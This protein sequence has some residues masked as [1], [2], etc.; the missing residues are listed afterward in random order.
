ML[1]DKQRKKKGLGM[2]RR[3]PSAITILVANV[4][5]APMKAG[6]LN[7]ASSPN[8]DSQTATV[9]ELRAWYVEVVGYDPMQAPENA[10]EAE[11]R[12]LVAGYRAEEAAGR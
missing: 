9:A 2:E 7:R 4:R 11:L 3:R 1:T 8:F 12:S 5:S 10:T 6:I